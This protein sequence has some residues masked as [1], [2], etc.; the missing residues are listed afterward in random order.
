MNICLAI[1]QQ[2]PSY[3]MS[4][5]G[6]AHVMAIGPQC[7]TYFPVNINYFPT[8][9]RPP[10]TSLTLFSMQPHCLGSIQIILSV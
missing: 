6:F 1:Y 5:F 10:G 3:N 8:I 2:L 9:V 7:F 4:F